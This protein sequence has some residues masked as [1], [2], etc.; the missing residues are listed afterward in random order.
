MRRPIRTRKAAATASEKGVK[1]GD[2]GEQTGIAAGTAL[3]I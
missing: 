1:Q 3:Q 2:L